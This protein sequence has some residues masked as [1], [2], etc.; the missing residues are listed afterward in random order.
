[1][2]LTIG[3]ALKAAGLSVIRSPLGGTA[4]LLLI[5]LG[6]GAAWGREVA[7]G[8]PSRLRWLVGWWAALM[9]LLFGFLNWGILALLPR[10]G[11]SFG[12]L[13]IGQ[14]GLNMLTALV[15]LAA[16]AAYKIP[17]RR[18]WMSSTPTNLKKV[19]LA[20]CLA[21]VLIFLLAV[22]SLYFE[23]FNLQTTHFAIPTPQFLTTRPLRIL[24]ISD[25]HI[26]RLTPR[27]AAVLTQ[28]HD[29]QPDLIVL[30][31][32]YLNLDYLD[33]PVSLSEARRFLS[34][35]QA[36]Y[37][38]FAVSGTV[39]PPRLMEALFVD[40]PITVLQNQSQIIS[41]PGGDLHLIGVSYTGSTGDAQVLSRLAKQIPAQDFSLLLYHTPDL[42]ESAALA[43]INLY[44]AGHTHGGQVRLPLYGAVV[45][46]STYGKR[47]ESGLY[48]LD[49]MQLYVS[50]GLGME[51][52][53]LPR[54]R[55]LCPP[56]LVL[57]EVGGSQP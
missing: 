36:P 14:F 1:M 11:L 13:G 24:Q 2:V 25:L 54:V 55:F 48:S 34:Q 12:A 32:D 21:Q 8:M 46:F 7:W 16:A 50:R 39:D 15:L 10:L 33:D 9:V 40:L 30:T 49:G 20:A 27:E 47:F 5:A 51:G 23:P 56:E 57:V 26:E 17:T 44:L 19:I 37:G 52:F 45:T 38:I 41:L 29:L 53:G 28:V 18:G 42:A 31:G 6:I 22:Y 4:L 3:M 35:L 43:G